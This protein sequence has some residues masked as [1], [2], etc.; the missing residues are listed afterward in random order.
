ML[1]KSAQHEIHSSQR[2][3]LFANL[4]ASFD[5]IVTFMTRLEIEERYDAGCTWMPDISEIKILH[6]Y[7]LPVAIF[8]SVGILLNDTVFFR[9]GRL[10]PASLFMR[11]LLLGNTFSGNSES[12]SVFWSSH[13]SNLSFESPF[14]NTSSGFSVGISTGS[15]DSCTSSAIFRAFL[16]H[17]NCI[18]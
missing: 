14:K 8:R 16:D 12:Q 7:N 10:L 18:N 17:S 11:L 9:W 13:S 15:V 4:I 3:W 2:D 6:A 1:C 5:S